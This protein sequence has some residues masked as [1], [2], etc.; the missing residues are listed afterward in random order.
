MNWWIITCRLAFHDEDSLFV[1]EAETQTEAVGI[2]ERQLRDVSNADTVDEDQREFYLNH[3][4]RCE[5]QPE[6]V[7]SV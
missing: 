6:V 7:R 5:T 3:V 1:V 2:A 4:V